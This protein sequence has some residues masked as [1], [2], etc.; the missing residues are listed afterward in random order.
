LK[1]FLISIQWKC[2]LRPATVS[3]AL[4]AL[5]CSTTL[6]ARLYLTCMGRTERQLSHL[7]RDCQRRS[8]CEQLSLQPLHPERSGR[9]LLHLPAQPT[10]RAS[11]PV[12]WHDHVRRSHLRAR[13]HHVSAEATGGYCC[14]RRRPVRLLECSHG[15]YDRQR[16]ERH[17][18]AVRRRPKEHQPVRSDPRHRQQ[19]CDRSGVCIH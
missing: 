19:P 12:P 16:P 10:D 6:L 4:W 3:L 11:R 18:P 17:P 8:A 2:L 9:A 13:Q 5:V 1:H 7:R 14:C 15:R